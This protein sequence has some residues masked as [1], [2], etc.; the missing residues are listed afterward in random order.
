MPSITLMI[1]SLLRSLGLGSRSRQGPDDAAARPHQ[2]PRG[3]AP[4]PAAGE[5]QIGGEARTLRVE[6]PRRRGP[7]PSRPGATETRA[8]AGNSGT[9][10]G[11]AS[12][13]A[14][15]RFCVAAEHAE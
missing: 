8:T 2:R 9:P 3:V 1:P 10:G 11:Y 4:V 14:V 7:R 12:A 5:A 15:V 6:R 13:G